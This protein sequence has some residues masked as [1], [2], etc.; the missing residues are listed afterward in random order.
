MIATRDQNNILD[1]TT[2]SVQQHAAE[3]SEQIATSNL[4]QQVDCKKQLT[5]NISLQTD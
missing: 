2:I 3:N 4:Q 5:T 1:F